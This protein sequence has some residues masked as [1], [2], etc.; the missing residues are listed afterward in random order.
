[1]RKADLGTH[2]KMQPARPLGQL[3]R[4]LL[5][6]NH[7]IKHLLAHPKSRVIAHLGAQAPSSGGKV[8]RGEGGGEET[9]MGVRK[10]QGLMELNHPVVAS[11]ESREL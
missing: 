2:P 8:E 1:M 3:L 4:W 10:T 9:K 7:Y 5:T 6:Q 11:V